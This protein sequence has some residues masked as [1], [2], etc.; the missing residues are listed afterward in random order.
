MMSSPP[1]SRIGTMQERLKMQVLALQVAARN[2]ETEAQKEK[3]EALSEAAE[4]EHAMYE[5]MVGS[6]NAIQHET[7]EREYLKEGLV[8]K[9]EGVFGKLRKMFRK[10]MGKMGN[11][12][13][14]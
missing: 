1:L 13:G 9:K 2:V 10:V 3:L 6:L 14:N 11:G 5:G 12:F 8:G 7:N 4:H